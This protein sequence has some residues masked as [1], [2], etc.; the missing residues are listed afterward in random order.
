MAYYPEGTS[1]EEIVPRTKDEGTSIFH[2][3][4]ASTLD[5]NKLVQV[6][7]NTN[8]MIESRKQGKGEDPT[9]IKPAQMVEIIKNESPYVQNALLEAPVKTIGQLQNRIEYLKKMEANKQDIA[10]N[11]GFITRMATSLPGMVFDI[12]SIPLFAGGK[13][14]SLAVQGGGKLA[15]FGGGGLYWGG[16]NVAWSATNR[17][18]TGDT[19]EH[20]YMADY[21]LGHALGGLHE[22]WQATRNADMPKKV[23]LVT[24]KGKVV[25]EQAAR[26]IEKETIFNNIEKI[27]RDL[28]AHEA[29]VSNSVD[30][31]GK[32]KE[33]AATTKTAIKQ[34]TT[35]ITKAT[36]DY[37]TSSKLYE[38]TLKEHTTKVNILDKEIKSLEADYSEMMKGKQFLKDATE[39]I[40]KL[41]E[42]TIELVKQKKEIEALLKK[43]NPKDATTISLRSKIVDDLNKQIV[44]NDKKQDFLKKGIEDTHNYR[45]SVWGTEK[46]ERL[47]ALKDEKAA[48]NIKIGQLNEDHLPISNTHMSTIESLTNERNALLK[49]E[50]YQKMMTK[51]HKSILDKTKGKKPVKPKEMPKEDYDALVKERDSLEE[52][53]KRVEDGT[54]TIDDYKHIRKNEVNKLDEIKADIEALAEKVKTMEDVE[55]LIPLPKWMTKILMSPIA[56]VWASPNAAVVG[57]A[58]KLR[59][60]TLNMGLINNYNAAAVKGVLQGVAS[61]LERN[62]RNGLVTYR[63]EVNPSITDK[64]YKSLVMDEAFN[65]ISKMQVAARE[66][67]EA[68]LPYAEQLA[69]FNENLGKASKE[70]TEGL[71]EAVKKNVNDMLEDYFEYFH[72]RGNKA[73]M[74]GFIKSPG[75]GYLPHIWDETKILE[76]PQYA[77]QLLYEAQ[78]KKFRALN[79]V[80]TDEILAEFRQA[81]KN[82]IEIAQDGSKELNR[83]VNLIERGQPGPSVL[84][85]RSID[86][87][88]ADVKHLLSNDFDRIIGKYEFRT[89]GKIALK[90]TTG[91]SNLAEAEAMIN[92]IPDATPQ[93]KDYL[94]VIVQDILG[95]REVTRNPFS[96]QARAIKGLSS[97]STAT[98]M[99]GFGLTSTLD[100][101]QVYAKFGGHKIIKHTKEAVGDVYQMY[102]E[103]NPS[104]QNFIRLA[105]SLGEAFF[106]SKAIRMDMEQN[107]D[108]VGRVQHYIDSFI[109][110][111]AVYGGLQP[112]TDMGRMLTSI[113]TTDFIARMSVKE[114]LSAH[115]IKMLNGMGI[116]IDRLPSIRETMKVDKNGVIGNY[117]IT[118]WGA[119]EEEMQRINWITQQETILHPSA[120][121]LPLP[122]TDYD[123]GGLVPRI[124]TKFMRFSVASYESMLLRNIQEA[125]ADKLVG[126]GLNFAMATMILAARD[127]VK[128][129]DKQRYAYDGG[130]KEKRLYLDALLFTNP[131]ALPGTII[132]TTA[133]ILGVENT[134]GFKGHFQAAPIK[135]LSDATQGKL[136]MRLPVGSIGIDMKKQTATL[137]NQTYN[138]HQMAQDLP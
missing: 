121:T 73:N 35:E 110:K 8:T 45:K 85:A 135:L 70:F 118:T 108:S 99:L 66:G 15:S 78:V 105:G 129:E 123:G 109:N 83:V 122:M 53:Y 34:K 16:T 3:L 10:K 134:K 7:T 103:G 69:K 30:A 39:E 88:D 93:E 72:K 90:E 33:I 126:L 46:S 96:L 95:T 82:V 138:L 5:V 89:L 74:E 94:A 20:S 80:E 101:A 84:K 137:L 26:E 75:K 124:L 59:Q 71:N 51:I 48:T 1:P 115:D 14:V 57:F 130:D 4:A 18:L 58:N 81:A 77:E 55:K 24:E 91:I 61:K 37:V 106:A 133:D 25:D 127:A 104:D 100:M 41:K 107:I 86:V 11:Q 112:V 111:A 52:R 116:S 62:I 22:T 65:V 49:Q 128:P 43:T 132:D 44:S 87:F 28:A 68:G 125:N 54:A 19:S 9:P 79:G 31:L 36:K 136:S 131:V 113:M 27:D 42:H 29:A 97:L 38:A 63:K 98:S 56:K 6:Y 114:K 117:D 40:T 32:I 92:K 2:D 76:N 119:L 67:I 17:A 60:S 102:K 64:E 12:D 50:S 47:K 23:E 13:A 21:L 120:S